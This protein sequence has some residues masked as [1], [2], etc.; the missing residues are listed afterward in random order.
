M[1]RKRLKLPVGIQTFEVL[2]KEGYVYVDKTKY[3]I[4]LIDTGKIYFLARP[5]RFG[6]SMTVSTFDALFSG[7]N[8]LFKGL[9]AEEFLNRHEFKPSP[10]IWLDMS[11]VTTDCGIDALR[12]SIKRKTSCVFARLRRDGNSGGTLQSGAVRFGSSPQR[13]SLGD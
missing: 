8:E 13:C 6:K 9:Y 7:D 4:D 1:E 2:R 3:L 12:A 5:R 10:V 11:K